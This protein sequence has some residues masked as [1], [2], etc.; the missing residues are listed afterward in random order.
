[1]LV[2]AEEEREENIIPIEV[3]TRTSNSINKSAKSIPGST[4]LCFK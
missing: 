1:M 3:I 4:E 2:K